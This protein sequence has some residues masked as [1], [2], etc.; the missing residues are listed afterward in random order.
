MLKRTLALAVLAAA[1][2]GQITVGPDVWADD[3]FQ[4]YR[5]F[6][7]TL[8]QFDRKLGGCP[9]KGLDLAACNA[10]RGSFDA[11]LWMQMRKDAR[12]VFRLR[13]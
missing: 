7:M 12:E 2:I 3:E 10:A 8:D 6:V 5:K 4:R 9:A 13:Q 11:A 1:A